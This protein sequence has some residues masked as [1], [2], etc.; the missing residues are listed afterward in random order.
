MLKGL[1]CFLTKISIYKQRSNVA[2]IRT[3]HLGGKHGNRTEFPVNTSVFPCH[4]LLLPE[5]Q[6]GEPWEE[7][8]KQC[9]FK[10]RGALD[11]ISL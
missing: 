11:R 2:T 6:N 7:P 8:K 5:V 10:I 4:T 1:H 3:E 9:S